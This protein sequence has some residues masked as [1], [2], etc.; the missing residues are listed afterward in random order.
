MLISLNEIKKLVDVHISDDQLLK[1]IGARLVEIESVEDLSL[2][3]KKIY[4]A[5]VV[6]A[7]PIEGTHLSLC[8]IDAGRDLN[9]S[10]DPEHNGYIQVVCGAPNVKAG[11]IAAWL[12][13]GAI[14]PASYNTTEPF[15]LSARKLRGFMSFGM[16]AGADELALGDDHSGIIEL[17]PNLTPGTPFSQSYDLDDKIIEVENKSLTHRPDC[18]GLIGFAREVAGILGQ[19]FSEPDFYH[20]THIQDQ[21]QT[22]P[23]KIEDS[24]ICPRYSCAIF[25]I[26]KAFT[27]RPSYLIADDIF[28][29]KSGMRP[30][31]PIV[32]LTNI[33]MLKT[34]QPLHAFD[35]DKFITI[36]NKEKPEIG[37]RLARKNETLHLIDDRKVALTENDIV[38]TSSDIPVAL[39]GAMGGKTTEI[40]SSTKTI[41][42]ESASFSLYNLRKT[43]MSHGLFSEAITRFTKGQPATQTAIVLARALNLLKVTPKLS[44]DISLVPAKKVVISITPE[45][46]NSILGSSY[47]KELITKTL[48]NVG[49]SISDNFEVTPPF[50]RTDIKIKEDIAEEIGRL[51]GFD[52]LKLSFPNRPFTAPYVD[53]VLQ[54][55]TLIRASLSGRLGAHEL[56]TYSFVSDSLLQKTDLDPEN[57]YKITNSISPELER[58]RPSLIPSLLDKFYMNVKAGYRDFSL[59]ELNQI[60]SKAYGLTSEGTPKLKTS[61]GLVTSNDFYYI[62]DLFIEL[63]HDLRRVIPTEFTFKPIESSYLPMF[64]QRR[65]LAIYLKSNDSEYL[66]GT[67]G[68]LKTSVRDHFKLSGNLSALEITI[69][70][71]VSTAK[72][73]YSANKITPSE[74]FKRQNRHIRSLKLSRYPSASR[75]LTIKLASN[76]PFSAVESNIKS[77]LAD[78]ETNNHIHS[79]LEPISIYRKPVSTT[80]NLSFRLVFQNPEKTFD[81]REV[82][83]IME[84]I[85]NS[86]SALGAEVV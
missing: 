68:E 86:L 16:L 26:P 3:Y 49:F 40:D 19:P 33:L 83:D 61:L 48:Q 6:S 77:T 65:T 73:N 57:C 38:I 78:L 46:I 18:F 39:A 70:H 44:G 80:K 22:I 17:S 64:E 43:Q 50:W 25:D 30:I 9:S 63:A 27:S 62:K 12:A 67:L 71:C 10:I 1:L 41:L 8:Q 5:K 31:S 15:E 72:S 53:P 35:Y 54:L 66:I 84:K 45:E 81:S 55:K 52:N 69:D 82:S 79:K 42:L 21:Q 2:K 32:D 75:D 11:M 37:V 85:T 4:A 13:P 7:A 23:I 47:S 20:L 29:Y 36:G 74:T 14:V 51:L 60:T 28:L 34:G 59:Y 58:F 24:Q 76:I 56:L